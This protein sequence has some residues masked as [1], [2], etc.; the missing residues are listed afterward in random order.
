MYNFIDRD[1]KEKHG[2]DLI[3]LLAELDHMQKVWHP[4]ARLRTLPHPSALASE[5]GDLSP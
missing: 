1:F 3:Y 4:P 2:T 5:V